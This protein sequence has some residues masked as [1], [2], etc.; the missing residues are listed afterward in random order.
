MLAG[1]RSQGKTVQDEFG[2]KFWRAELV[3]ATRWLD[4]AALGVPATPTAD[5][6]FLTIPEYVSGF[7]LSFGIKF[8]LDLAGAAGAPDGVVNLDVWPL[9]GAAYINIAQIALPAAVAAG[10]V[11]LAPLRDVTIAAAAAVAP[12]PVVGG[13]LL[14][15]YVDPVRVAGGAA[16]LCLP[17]VEII[18]DEWLPD[19]DPA[20]L[21]YL[22]FTH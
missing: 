19:A 2:Q 11:G 6:A 18:L 9:G 3:P 20:V 15:A 12:R 8:V 13:D 22:Q 10:A 4:I 5:C 7:Y 17:F 1:A 21:G 16:G 14:V